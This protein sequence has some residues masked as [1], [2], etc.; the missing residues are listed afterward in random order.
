MPITRL[1]LRNIGPITNTSFE[2]DP[3][4]NV[5]VGPNNSGKTTALV[6]L[7][8][9]LLPDFRLPERLQRRNS[10]YVLKFPGRELSGQFFHGAS[11]PEHQHDYTHDLGYRAFVPA[12]RLATDFHS[13]GPGES[14][15]RPQGTIAYVDPSAD[16][17]DDALW[18][19]DK[20][21]IQKIVDLD[22]RSYRE[23]RPGI[24]ALLNLIAALASEITEG[25]PMEFA[26]IGEDARGLY[27]KFNTPDGV[28][29]M[30]FLSQGT[31]SLIQWCAQFVVGFAEFYKFPDTLEGL[32]GVLLIDE[33]DAHLHPGWQRRILPALTKRFP[34]LQIICAAHSP[35]TIAGLHAGQ[36]HL[37]RRDPEGGISVTRN[38]ADVI[39]WSADEIYSTFLDVDPTDL[40]TLERRRRAQQLRAITHPTEAEKDELNTLREE[41]R[42]GLSG[43]SVREESEVLAGELKRAAETAA[44]GALQTNGRGA[45]RPAAAKGVKRASRRRSH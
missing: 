12:T 9:I 13:K 26:G 10:A 24:R 3:R 2:F 6:T 37:L 31:Q 23:S 21:I 14:R 25:F 7:A 36:I 45:K 28:V 34:A 19:D 1:E 20:Q 30:G 38:T 16:I 41:I 40:V 39:G 27:P 11:V 22:Y 8:Q 44:K 17:P 33:I 32:D 18:S 35:M 4:V 29:P 15:I 43:G 42:Q 5:L